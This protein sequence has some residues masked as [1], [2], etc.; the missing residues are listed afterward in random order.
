[1]LGIRELLSL[2]DAVNCKKNVLDE[3]VRGSVTMD[4]WAN[5]TLYF[6]RMLQSNLTLDL[7]Q[8]MGTH[9]SFNN[10]ADG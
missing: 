6:Q 2:A 7:I 5:E 9:N 10:K 8:T 3:C 1:M 4:T